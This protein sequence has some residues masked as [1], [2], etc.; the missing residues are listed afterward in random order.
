M[1]ILILNVLSRVAR[2]Y[3][4]VVAPWTLKNRPTAPDGPLGPVGGGGEGGP[5]HCRFFLAPNPKAV[6]KHFYNTFF[7]FNYF[8]V[9]HFVMIMIWIKYISLYT[10]LL[11][12]FFFLLKL[13]YLFCINLQVFHNTNYI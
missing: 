8:F 2:L 6:Y 10:Y 5:A 11:Y 1:L 13:I 4:G 9:L 3:S 12:E 7:A